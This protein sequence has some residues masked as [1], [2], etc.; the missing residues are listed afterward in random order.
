MSDQQSLT[1]LS[2]R[3]PK[4]FVW[5]VASSAFQ[6]EG[7]A[8]ADGKGESIWDEFCRVPG[9]IADGSDGQI[10]CDHYHRLDADLD[11]IAGLGVKA[12]RFSI[13]WPRIQP[14]GSGP[15]LE[16]GL[17][18]YDRLVDGLLKRGIQPY[19]TLYHWDLPAELQKRHQGWADRGTAYRFAEYAALVARRLGD[20]ARCIATH[21]EPWVT[22]TLGHELGVFAPGVK[23]RA[24][25]MQ[26]AHHCL[27]SHGLAMQAMRSARPGLSLGIVLNLAPVY[28]AS[29]SS[30]DKNLALR[31]DG[32]LVR[33]Y[34]DA[35]MGR[36]YPA[37]ILMY[38]G[39]DAPRVQAED[40]DLIAQPLD[41][42]GVN[43]Y[44]PIISV[45]AR[46]FCPTR[47]G[48]PVTDMGWEVAPA[49][50]TELLLRLDRD[51]DLPPLF[52]TENGAAYRDTI[53]EGGVVD[54]ERRGYIES[55][56][57]AV[58]D[59]INH[60]VDVRGYFVWSLLDNFEWAS[61]YSK[62]FGIYYVDYQTQARILKR[63]GT[64]FKNLAAA[65]ERAR[66]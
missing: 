32:L 61:G 12:Y 39:A 22:A 66:A 16:S 62:R 6:I 20:R 11:L 24:V 27:L 7:A 19:P 40:A 29:D 5:G 8:R 63:S 23:D 59:A 9:A 1:A 41:F 4:H 65:F 13:S 15:V 54:D 56:V 44:H 37:D 36:A 43:Y 26:V 53:V 60:G 64:W 31:E 28:A 17:G 50:F 51:Y 35:L 3:F 45:A 33:W 25:A 48:V 21:N 57:R 14:T 58:A 42:L 49:S 47:D 55:H 38:L 18:F 2:A 34:M 46:P 30:A 52:I 10:A